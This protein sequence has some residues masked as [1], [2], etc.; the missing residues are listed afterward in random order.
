MTPAPPLPSPARRRG[1]HAA[2]LAHAPGLRDLPWRATRDPWAVLVSEVMLQQTQAGRVVGPF[3]RFVTR[4][5]TP[6]ACAA[7][8]L[9]EVVQAWAGLGYNRRAAQLHRA[10]RLVV[11][12]HGGVVPADLDAL[13]ALP[14]IG[15]YTARAVLAFAYERDHGVIDTNVRRVLARAVAGA[16]VGGGGEQVLADALVP[17]G[18]AWAWNQTLME[19]GALVCGARVPACDACPLARRC[20]WRRDR[21]RAVAAGACPP[22]DPANPVPRQ[23]RFEGSDRQG[24]GRLV[25]ALRRGPVPPTSLPAACGWPEDAPRAGRIAARLVAEGLAR[26]RRGGVLVLP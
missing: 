2:V 7:A 16:P 3:C 25:A 1:L 23:S 5:P 18:R 4:F 22:P 6:A 19:I 26:R 17:A 24:R 13:V 20:T 8:T 10:A 15:P 21:R 9:G 11:R 12:D 14:G